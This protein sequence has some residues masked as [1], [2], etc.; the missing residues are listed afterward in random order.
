M[1]DGHCGSR[2]SIVLDPV[3]ITD[4]EISRR[5]GRAGLGAAEVGNGGS[6]SGRV[7][8][9]GR[10]VTAATGARRDD[11]DAGNDERVCSGLARTARA[12]DSG[13]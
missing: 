7:E 13:D 5:A 6:R 12:V 10:E 3:E 2:R 9:N 4:A 1:V 11:T 8:E